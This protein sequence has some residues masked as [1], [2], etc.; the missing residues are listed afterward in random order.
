MRVLGGEETLRRGGKRIGPLVSEMVIRDAREED[1]EALVELDRQC[2]MGGK[3]ELV[4]DRSPDFFARSRAYDNFRMCVAE[5]DGTII[6]VGGVTFKTLRVHGVSDRWA[7]FYDLRVSPA[8]RRRGV[9]RLI[10]DSLAEAVRDAGVSRAYSW[11]VEGN[12]A[13]HSFVRERGSRPVA[14]CVFAL[15]SDC[16]YTEPAG[17]ESMTEHREEVVSLLEATYQPY[18]FTPPWDA[19]TVLRTFDRLAPLGWQGPYGKR[20]QGRWAVCFGLWDYSR[21]TR[22]VFRNGRSERRVRPFF[23]T[24]LGWRDPEHL[25]EGLRA[26]ETMVAKAGGTLI[27]PY[28]PGNPVGAF[29]PQEAFRVGM[30]LYARGLLPEA[31][32]AETLVFIDPM[33]L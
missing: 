22:M 12:T 1:N 21:V 27:L 33:D 20:V 28:G 7:Y 32:Q 6:G 11:V 8:H 5:H 23:L 4:F 2:V 30:T 31:H 26:A 9:A 25:Q 10:A 15:L 17:F 19:K 29:I 13:S 16:A 14:V 3:I 18:H 24:P